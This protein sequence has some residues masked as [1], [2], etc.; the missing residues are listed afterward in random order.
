MLHYRFWQRH[1]NGDH[2]IIG[3]TLELD[4]KTYTIIGV[5]RNVGVRFAAGTAVRRSS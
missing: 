3:K 1:F 2:A 5:T 4:R